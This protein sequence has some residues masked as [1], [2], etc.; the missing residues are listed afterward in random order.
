MARWS[1]AASMGHVP[2]ASRR[3]RWRRARHAGLLP[4]RSRDGLVLEASTPRR[5]GRRRRSGA[6][7]G[8]EGVTHPSRN[9]RKAVPG[10]RPTRPTLLVKGTPDP[11]AVALLGPDWEGVADR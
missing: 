10:G 7:P 4:G 6:E 2:V 3:V 8:F 5:A 11:V 1:R 9:P